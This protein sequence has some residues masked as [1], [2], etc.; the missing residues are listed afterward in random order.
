MPDTLEARNPTWSRDELILTLDLYF[1][2]K[3]NPPGKTSKDIVELS[4]LLNK[5]GALISDRKADFRNPNGVYMKVMNFRRFDPTYIS[6][7]KKGLQRGGKLEE[8]VWRDFAADPHKL[9]E[10]ANAIRLIVNKGE[11]PEASEEEDEE[12]AE[13]EEGR[14]LTRIHRS[15]ERSRKLVENKKASVVKANGHLKC[16]ACSFDFE[17]TY[18]ERGKSF[19]EAH[20]VKPV[21]T[22]AAGEKT[23]LE[24]LVLLCSNCHRIVHTQRPW[25]TV[26]ELRQLIKD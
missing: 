12:F 25:L 8:D 19:I 13:A 22:L 4:E 9:S 26:E 23:K 18:G 21:H 7:G 15:R 2:F 10:T 16:E 20:H 6:Q 24:D 5:M 3:G 14:I 1:R 11:I 17:V